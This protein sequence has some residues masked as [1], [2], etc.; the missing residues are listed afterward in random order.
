VAEVAHKIDAKG[1][2]IAPDKA[3]GQSLDFW[4]GKSKY[5]FELPI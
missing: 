5:I 1:S 4:V 3:L 2:E